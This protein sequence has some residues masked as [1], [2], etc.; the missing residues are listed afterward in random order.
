MDD[1]SPNTRY[2]NVHFLSDFLY[3]QLELGTLNSTMLS[4]V[5]EQNPQ[6]YYL[7]QFCSSFGR[8]LYN[9]ALC[10]SVQMVQKQ[11]PDPFQLLPANAKK[12][13][14]GACLF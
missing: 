12:L 1:G 7:L 8:I 6:N 9:I 14:P 10:R 3:S 2:K 5:R 11:I 4:I 13:S